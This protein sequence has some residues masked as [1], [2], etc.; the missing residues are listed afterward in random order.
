MSKPSTH[1]K[2]RRQKRLARKVVWDREMSLGDQIDE[3]EE[4]LLDRAATVVHARDIIDVVLGVGEDLDEDY[5]DEIPDLLVA[6][7]RFDDRITERGWTFD[8]DHA[9]EGLAVWYFAP[10]GFEPDDDDAEAV[11][12]VFFTTDSAIEDH[13]NFPQRVSVILVGADT[14]TRAPQL[15]PDRFLEQ[16]EL[17]EAYRPGQPKPDFA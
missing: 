1:K 14:D 10:S 3:I 12:R 13:E 6:A 9:I 2:A 5:P 7:K 16:I 17:I 11:T 8:P 4:E 15:S